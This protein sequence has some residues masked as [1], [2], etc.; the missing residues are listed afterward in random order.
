MFFNKP[1]YLISNSSTR[2]NLL[3]QVGLNIK[4]VNNTFNESKAKEY[5]KDLNSLQLSETLSELKLKHYLE[6]N[7]NNSLNLLSSDQ[8]ASCEQKQ[9]NKVNSIE[10]AF[11]TLC[12][13]SNKTVTLYSSSVFYS[14]G[15]IIKN[16]SSACLKIKKLK[17]QDIDTYLKINKQNALACLGCIDFEGIGVNLVESV[18][19]GNYYTILG[20]PM[21]EFLNSLNGI[22]KWVIKLF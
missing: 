11:N 18:V 1:I 15:N 9:I 20:F 8:T 6:S 5:L 7:V 19:Y 22:S 17:Q 10:D 12:L 21:F 16:T 2:L 14:N 13:I 4:Q 3:K